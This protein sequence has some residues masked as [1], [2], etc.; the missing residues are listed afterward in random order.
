MAYVYRHIRLDKNEP[1]YIGIG[2]DDKG[3]YSRAY[4]VGG[5][6]KH[7]RNIVNKAGYEVEIILD[8]LSWEEANIK[9]MEFIKLYGRK[10]VGGVLCN[11]TDGGDGTK[12]MIVSEETRIKKKIAMTGKKQSEQTKIKIGAANS[13]KK[14]SVE[15]IKKMSISHTGKKLSVSHIEKI[16]ASN[17]GRKHSIEEREKRKKSLSNKVG[18]RIIQ[19][20]LFGEEV[21]SFISI[22]KAAKALNISINTIKQSLNGVSRKPI[23][24]IFKYEDKETVKLPIKNDSY[25][26]SI[27]QY[28]LYGNLINQYHS[29]NEAAIDL[30]V[31]RNTL[32]EIL[33]GI[34]KRPNYFLRQ[35]IFK[36]K[37]NEY[38]SPFVFQRRVFKLKDVA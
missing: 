29:L 36:Y 23:K 31:N 13:G 9:E 11:L 32:S 1:F 30:G 17:K 4:W 27:L 38:F 25:R 3:K 33:R 12:G 28:D 15:A 10:Q 18:L 14:P 8:N 26:K 5:R 35:F 2:S 24:F 34:T 20:T 21:N 22:R 16:V 6:T 7:W 19:F 37:P